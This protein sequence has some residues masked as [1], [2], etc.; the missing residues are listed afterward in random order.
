MSETLS[1]LKTQRVIPVVRTRSVGETGEMVRILYAAGM[2]LIELTL[3]IPDVLAVVAQFRQSYPDLLIGIGTIRT[4]L[5][6]REAVDV[7]AS[8]LITYKA[9][10]S[11]ANVGQ[12]CSVPYILGAWTPTEVD[13]CLELGSAVV[14]W[15]P[16]SIHGPAAL[17]ELQGPLPDAK[18]FPTGGIRVET[19]QEWLLQRR[20][21]W[22]LGETYWGQ[23]SD[24]KTLF[25][26][27]HGRRCA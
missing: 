24:T 6:A 3:T 5:Q 13:R 27:A 4:A 17:R 19:M 7:G 26:H 21:R 11:V 10:E 16:A 1:Q 22:G 20:S 14:K 8:L 15:F 9:S 12:Q 23:E 25:W 18:F 2:R